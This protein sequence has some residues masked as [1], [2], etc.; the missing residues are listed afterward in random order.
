MTTEQQDRWLEVL[1]GKAKATDR[2][3]RQAQSLRGFFELQQAEDNKLQLDPQAEKRIMNMMRAKGAFDAP[4]A[5]TVTNRPANLL[6]QLLNWLLP[7]EGGHAGRYAAVAAVA[8]AVVAGPVFLLQHQDGLPEDGGGM[9]SFPP[10][11]ASAPTAGIDQIH[12]I[13]PDPAEEASQVLAALA[14]H[15]IQTQAR[16]DGQ[17]R[18]ISVDVDAGNRQAVGAELQSLGISLAADGRLRVRFSLAR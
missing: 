11:G 3:T 9:K 18:V 8:F 2:E 10:G 15:G 14:R 1:S 17:D 4:E 12:V 13:A 16:V 5:A 6:G 7:P